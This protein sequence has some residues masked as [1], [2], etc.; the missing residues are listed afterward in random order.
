MGASTSIL[1]ALCEKADNDIR[2]CLNTLQVMLQYN[3][4]ICF[5]VIHFGASLLLCIW[6]FAC[7]S[8]VHVG[9]CSFLRFYMDSFLHWKSKCLCF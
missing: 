2:T 8:D 5:A 7:S 1:I 9:T 6:V 4:T 3:S